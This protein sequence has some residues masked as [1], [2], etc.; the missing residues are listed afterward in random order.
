M[1]TLAYLF[2][3]AFLLDNI[4][5]SFIGLNNDVDVDVNVERFRQR[6]QNCKLFFIERPCYDKDRLTRKHYSENTMK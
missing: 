3:E 2:T 1:N 4:Y 5:D 6:V